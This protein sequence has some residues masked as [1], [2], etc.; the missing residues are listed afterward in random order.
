MSKIIQKNSTSSQTIFVGFLDELKK[1][2]RPFLMW[3]CPI[4]GLLS[5]CWQGLLEPG[6]INQC[7]LSAIY[8][9]TSGYCIFFKAK[10]R[11]RNFPPFNLI[12][13]F[14]AEECWYTLLNKF[15][16]P[17]WHL[18]CACLFVV[19]VR[20]HNFP[21]FN[22]ISPFSTEEC[23]YTLLNKFSSPFGHLCFVCL[24]D[25]LLRWSHFPPFNLISP[26][27]AEECQYTLWK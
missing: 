12:S 24:F 9:G 11:W 13:P 1:P 8:S 23:Q 26:F 3:N 18:C 27:S 22:L 15:S 19:M 20:E 10:A 4:G 17:F 21:P 25:A 7:I 6:I 5:T 16:S 2:K 14:S